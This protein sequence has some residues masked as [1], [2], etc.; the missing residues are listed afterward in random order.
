MYTSSNAAA[1]GF[2]SSP[3]HS[4]NV[5]QL[6]KRAIVKRELVKREPGHHDYHQ[7]QDSIGRGL[8][9]DLMGVKHSV[10]STVDHVKQNIDA[11]FFPNVRNSLSEKFVKLSQSILPGQH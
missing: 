4:S 11:H 2:G 10:S 5:E 9:K 8:K 3:H 7:D 6:A 1:C